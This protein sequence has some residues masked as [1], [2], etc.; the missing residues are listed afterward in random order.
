MGVRACVDDGV[1][2]V[3]IFKGEGLF[4]Y[5][6]HVLK[7]AS[8]QHLEDPQIEYYQGR[9]I[10]VESSKPL[11]VHVDD[12]P[13]THTPVTIRVLPRALRV[14]LPRDAPPHL[15]TRHSS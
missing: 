5:L 8:R 4:N 15:F 7:V 6:Q 2:D 13:F 10:F 14:R 11:P 12:E 9:D 1:L 3:C